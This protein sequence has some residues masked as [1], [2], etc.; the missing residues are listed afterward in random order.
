MNA[1]TTFLCYNRDGFDAVGRRSTKSTLE[2]GIYPDMADQVDRNLG[3]KEPDEPDEELKH[4]LQA[5][6]ARG[7]SEWIQFAFSGQTL[8]PN[9]RGVPQVLL[10]FIAVSFAINPELFAT[11]RKRIKRVG[12]VYRQ[13]AII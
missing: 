13:A 1:D 7:L 9:G 6:A 3:F 10:S 11:E 12:Y 8:H 5:V 2:V 4:A